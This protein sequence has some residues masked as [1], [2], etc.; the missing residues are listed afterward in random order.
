M[1]ASLLSIPL[2]T[3]QAAR[4]VPIIILLLHLALLRLE[5][6]LRRLL[7][8]ILVVRVDHQGSSLGSSSLLAATGA[9]SLLDAA[10]GSSALAALGRGGRVSAAVRGDRRGNAFLPAEFLKVLPV[11][12]KVVSMVV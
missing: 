12:E 6:L 1:L 2:D 4:Y 11:E 3:G 8:V 7:D 5:L 9:G 10:A